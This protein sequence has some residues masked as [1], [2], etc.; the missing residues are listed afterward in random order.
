MTIPSWEDENLGSMKRVAL[1]LA[2][3]V[4]EG[5]I[6]TYTDLR[7]DFP[8][9]AQIDRRVRDL[10]DRGW[11]IDTS[12]HDSTLGSDERRL[13]SMGEAVWENGKGPG[14]RAGGL[15]GARRR[16]VLMRDGNFCRSCGITPGEEYAESYETAQLDIARRTVKHADGS[17]S[18]MLITECRR[19]RMGAPRAETDEA[20]T[21]AALDSLGDMERKML[22]SW[23]QEDRRAFGRVELL[24]AAYRTM[25][26]E[27][28][29]NFREALNARLL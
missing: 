18:V 11:R 2:G 10:R 24:W 27:S 15:N 17:E 29:Q 4:G 22:A 1:W 28:R 19:C 8:A 5:G 12:R 7:K 25:P 23:V 20:G 21:I 26:A 3:T 13:V 14:K 6:F 9:V 16:E